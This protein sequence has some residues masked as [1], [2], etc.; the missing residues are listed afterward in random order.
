MNNSI[1]AGIILPD[2]GPCVGFR[3]GSS[4]RW[5]G[6]VPG[7]GRERGQG[8]PG[9]AGWGWGCVCAGELGLLAKEV[10]K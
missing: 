8:H 6:G 7:S 1:L 3:M 9:C 2:W 10:K 4:K 5:P